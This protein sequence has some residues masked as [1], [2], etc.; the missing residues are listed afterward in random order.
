MAH[1]NVVSEWLVNNTVAPIET[2][3][4]T[5]A[6]LIA[7]LPAAMLVPVLAKH[8]VEAFGTKKQEG[9]PEH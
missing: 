4:A 9:V 1:I 2:I 6:L 7:L 5:P 8:S 3:L